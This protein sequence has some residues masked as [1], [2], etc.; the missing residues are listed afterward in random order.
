M[1]CSSVKQCL[2]QQFEKVSAHCEQCGNNGIFQTHKT[3]HRFPPIL[4]FELL[5]KNNISYEM[6]ISIHHCHKKQK[7]YEYK[8]KAIVLYEHN[9]YKCIVFDENCNDY[10]LID[11]DKVQPINDNTNINYSNSRLLIYERN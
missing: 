8:M 6:C 7:I 2:L 11:D 5:D 10:V 1:Y 9:H 4:I 3:F